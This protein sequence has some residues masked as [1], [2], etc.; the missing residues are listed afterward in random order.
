M[1]RRAAATYCFCIA[2]LSLAA[3]AADDPPATAPTPPTPPAPRASAGDAPSPFETH[4][5]AGRD[6]FQ[7]RRY[8]EALKEFAAAI[9]LQPNHHDARMFGG[10]SAYWGRQPELALECWNPLLD[11]AKRNSNEEWEIERQRVMALS[12]L[13]ETDAADAVIDRLY[14]LRRG[15]KAPAALSAKGFVREHFYFGNLRVGVYEV[16]DERNELPEQWTFPV[17]QILPPGAPAKGNST[18]D[19][20]PLV[21]RLAVEST[22]LPG[23]GAGYQFAE[24]GPG[25][26][27]VYK[28][29]A[30]KPAYA[31]VR[32]LIEPLMTGKLD[33]VSA[34]KLENSNEF[35]AA[36][37]DPKTVAT[38][39]TPAPAAENKTPKPPPEAPKA[40]KDSD[41]EDEIARALTA[42]GFDPDVSRM[43]TLVT[44]LKDVKFDVTRAARLSQTDPGLAEKEIQ[45]LN[46]AFPHAQ[47]RAS[48]LV[49]L[50]SKAK[51][52]QVQSVLREAAKLPQ[53][54]P[55][56]D[57]V[58]LTAMNTRGADFSETLLIE[59]LK[60]SDFMIRQTTALLIG[61]MGDLRGLTQLFDDLKKADAPGCVILDV[62]LEELLGD[63]LGPPPQL[64]LENTDALAKVWKEN[65]AKWWSKHREKLEFSKDPKTGDATWKGK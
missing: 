31:E 35:A 11:S 17:T 5:K 25:Y 18:P 42:Q 38:A 63:V 46:T 28:L 4:I 54:E 56:L 23:G 14:E 37:D 9:Q 22:P 64:G 30:T 61:R 19:L 32:P 20:E 57:F 62:A 58:L 10:L 59:D 52:P 3:H 44:L 6:F 8:T 1:I 47:E 45:A 43:L 16:F 27:R 29:W 39:Q 33:P 49:E 55:Y 15:K 60:Q 51:S 24:Y 7:S 13:G 21:K 48:E 34:Q 50:I 2:L 53:R 26:K 40:T 41:R 65:A 12:A 36:A